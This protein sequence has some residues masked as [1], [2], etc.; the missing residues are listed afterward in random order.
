[1]LIL[2]G[3]AFPR[4]ALVAAEGFSNASTRYHVNPQTEKVEILAAPCIADIFDLS[5][6]PI[7]K[8]APNTLAMAKRKQPLDNNA[9]NDD[10]MDEDE[11]SDEVCTPNSLHH[12]QQHANS[13]G[14]RNG[15]RRL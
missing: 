7:S 9:K 4:A 1:M 10:R 15:Q 5:I 6:N 11:S 12:R 2:M 13:A 14:C 8:R 3:R